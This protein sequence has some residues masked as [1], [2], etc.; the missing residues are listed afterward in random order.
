MNPTSLKSV[1]RQFIRFTGVGAIGTGV[2]YLTLIVLV[3]GAAAPPVPASVAG[4]V[5][6]ALTNYFLNYRYT[7]NSNHRHREAMTR[8]FVV[9]LAGL[10]LNTLVMQLATGWLAL[11]Y[12]IA[13]VLAT[14][15]VLVWNFTGNRMWTFRE[16]LHE[17]ES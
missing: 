5:L 13:Q 8:F 15:M 14:G 11:H 17:P 3:Q 12:L 10:V 4:F 6:G 1:V 9:A 16:K 7:F 2:H